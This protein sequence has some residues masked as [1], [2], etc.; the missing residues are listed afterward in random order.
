MSTMASHTAG[1]SIVYSTVCSG[2]ARRKHQNSAS[3]VFVRG[4]HRWPVDSYHKGP[5]TWNMFPNGD[6]IM[7]HSR[8]LKR[9][10]AH[11]MSLLWFNHFTHLSW[12]FPARE[13]VNL[14]KG[15]PAY[16]TDNQASYTGPTKAVDG[17]KN[18]KWSAKS[19]AST[20]NVDRP[21]W[22]VDVRALYH[23]QKVLITNR[24]AARKFRS[25]ADV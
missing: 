15:K 19:C 17:N 10:D 24:E 14:A 23:I 13:P 22:A 16:Q 12:T 25:F 5:V 18:P 2:S 6:V 8:D 11:V 4:T 9:Y 20:K 21:W 7:T 3:L 1:V